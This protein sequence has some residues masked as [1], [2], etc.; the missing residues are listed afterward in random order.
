MEGGHGLAD[1]LCGDI[2]AS[3]RL[4]FSVPRHESDLPAFDAGAEAFTYDGDHGYWYLAGRGAT[5]AYPFGF[6]LSYTSFA[7]DGATVGVRG[8][9]VE[10]TATVRNSGPR[11]GSD[12]VQVY[13]TRIGSTRAERLVGFGRV[14]LSPGERGTVRVPVAT[15]A[16]AE[17]DLTA[18]AMVVP[19]G[20]YR[21]RVAR[22]AADPGVRVEAVLGGGP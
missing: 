5:P 8:G 2:D 17:R 18:H 11:T 19:P 3:G 12:V 4:P 15:D 20:R 14:T 1:V 22:H 13:A 7:V 21:L 16:V 10:V 9:A 6:G